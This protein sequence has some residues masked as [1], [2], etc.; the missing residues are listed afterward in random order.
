[1]IGAILLGNNVVNIL[2]SALTTS[3][4]TEAIPG[5]LGV[6]MATGVMTVLMLVF[7]EVL[8]KT[9]AITRPDDVARALSIPTVRSCACSGRSWT[10]CS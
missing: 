5:A 3:V 8:P 10:R 4:I 7:G 1:M 6:A 2:A 9:L